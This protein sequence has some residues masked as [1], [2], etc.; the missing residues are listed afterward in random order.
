MKKPIYCQTTLNHFTAEG[1]A[2]LTVDIHNARE[3][4]NTLSVWNN[5]FEIVEIPSV[6]NDWNDA[7]NIEENHYAEINDWARNFTGCDKVLFFPAIT[8]SPAA[9]QQSS[10]YAPIEFAH[11]DYTEQYADMIRD[12]QHPYHAILQPSM[13]RAG[14]S[15]EQLSQ[16]KRIL[17]LQLWRNTGTKLMDH[18]LALCDATTVPRSQLSEFRVER[19]GGVEAQFDSFV[20]SRPA[21]G[22]ANDWYCYP[23]MEKQEVLL[24]RAFDSDCVDKGT[25]FWT[26]HTAF[27]DPHSSSN[28][29][30]S[31][32]MRAICIFL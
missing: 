6:V 2:P 31:V 16:A 14:L 12:A 1:P 28:P 20:M 27:R 3:S 32:E 11:S 26:P 18:P 25:P 5:G 13:T 8:R 22:T 15:A 23:Q 10:D 29:R 19:Y 17:T 24:F 9:E 30:S 4:T 21:D 7:K